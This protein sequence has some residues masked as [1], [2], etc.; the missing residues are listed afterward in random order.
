MGDNQPKKEYNN[1]FNYNVEF[2]ELDKK[3]PL[4]FA[5]CELYN[6]KYKK[7]PPYII[8]NNG[9]IYDKS[10]IPILS[11]DEIKNFIELQKKYPQVINDCFDKLIKI[12]EN[13]EKQIVISKNQKT[14][15]DEIYDTLSSLNIYNNKSMI[16]KW[17]LFIKSQ[18]DFCYF[19]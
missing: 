4:T 10:R 6:G 15:M 12:L 16:D 9:I 14:P 7:F 18:N 1:I 8:K 13:Q 19:F 3:F 11:E 2:M 17:I 5:R